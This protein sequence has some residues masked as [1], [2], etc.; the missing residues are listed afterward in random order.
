MTTTTAT[1]SLQLSRL[2]GLTWVTW[3]QHR[4]A[5]AGVGALMAA[6]GILLVA[7]GTVMRT[8]YARLGLDS[9]GDMTGRACQTSLFAF[10]QQY[11][12]WA[13]ILPACL[14]LIPG[15][16][17]AFVGAPLIARELESGTFRFAWTQSR[18]RARLVLVKLALL[19]CVLTALALGFSLL[20]GWWFRLWQPLMGRMSMGGAYEVSGLVFAARTLFAFLLGALLGALIRRTVMAVAATATAWL[21]VV[22]SSTVYLRPLIKDPLVLNA[23]FHSADGWTLRSWVQDNAG[24]RF[25]VKSTQFIDLVNKARQ[26]GATSQKSLEAWL[27]EHHYTEWDAY[28]PG[29]RYWHFQLTE[30]AAYVLLALLLGAVTTWWVRRRA[31]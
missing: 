12:T 25:D 21:A 2:R 23:G 19:G 29:S 10:Q 8:T 1:R 22:W 14:M 18:R 3:R 11:Q 31:A 13:Q 20:F 16:I 4:T 6:A 5:L 15:L 27:A 26:Q 7:S 28:Q 9:C 30:A 17:G 24:H